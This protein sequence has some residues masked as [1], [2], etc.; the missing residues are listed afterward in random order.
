MYIIYPDRVSARLY[1]KAAG[2]WSVADALA[3]RERI[4]NAFAD[5]V[6]IGRPATILV[7]LVDFALQSTEV[8]E[9][10]APIQTALTIIPL[11]RQ[12]IVSPGAL[13]AL[14]AKRILRDAPFRLFA[15]RAEAVEWLGWPA[16]T[17]RMLDGAREV[18][19][20]RRA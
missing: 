11:E 20:L 6:A 2:F 8:T 16:D 3:F 18:A 13:V 19:A 14:Q 12:A 7:D 1:V 10:F 5:I 15:D 17:L 9:V 4:E